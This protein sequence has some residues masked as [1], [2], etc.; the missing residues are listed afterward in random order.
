[1]DATASVTGW[2]WQ[3]DTAAT[4]G[5]FQPASKHPRCWQGVSLV[6]P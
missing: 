1:M 3:E 6:V 2:L 5:L 4:A